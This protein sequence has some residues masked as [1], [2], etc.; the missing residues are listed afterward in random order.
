MS[1][2]ATSTLLHDWVAVIDFGGNHS[3]LVARK[4]R[5]HQVFSEIWPYTTPIAKILERRPKGI[6]LS[7]GP[8]SVFDEAAPSCSDEIF[9]AGIPVLGIDY[10]MHVMVQALGGKVSRGEHNEFGRARVHILDRT[11]L[12]AAIDEEAG[13]AMIGWMRHGDFV[14]EAPAGCDVMARTDDINV[15]AMRHTERQLFGIQFHPEV[16]ETSHGKEILRNFVLD[17]CGCRATWTMESFVESVVEEIRSQVGADKVL[18]ALSGGVDSAVAAAL[19]ERA[20]G[21]QLTCVYVNNGFMRAGES[22]KV[23]EFFSSRM[24]ECFRSVDASERFLNKLEGVA[25]PE[26]KRKLIGEE[27]IRVFEEEARELGEVRYLVQG[28]LYP[29]VIESVGTGSQ[30]IKSHHNVGGLPEHM[31][32][33]LIEPLR[34]LFKDEVRDLGIVLGLPPSIVWRQ[35]FPGPGLAVRVCGAIDRERLAIVRQADAIVCEEIDKAGLGRDIWQYFAVVTDT[36]SVGVTDDARTYGYAVAIRA[37]QSQD[38]MAAEWSRLPYELLDRMATR[39]MRE[40]EHVNRVV[41]DISSKPPATI[42]WE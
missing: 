17:I 27:F 11:D 28:T 1:Q 7:G 9:Q 2:G 29:D 19:V 40:V 21:E 15:V 12:L 36:R 39:I 4:V 8:V 20:V 13:G 14:E 34:Q 10:G 31:Q 25:D 42:E 6:I 32:L 38:A 24:S 5:E 26:L 33:D 35:P 22:E 37:V 23:C 30:G 18:A 3:H 41:Y 16:E